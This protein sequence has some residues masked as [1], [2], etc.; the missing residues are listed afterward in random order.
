M[1][2]TPTEIRAAV[3]DSNKKGPGESRAFL[4]F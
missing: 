3:H 1:N 4:V 2:G